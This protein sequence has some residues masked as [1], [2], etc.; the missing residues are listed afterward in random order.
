MYRMNL[1]LLSYSLGLGFTFLRT[2]RFG[3]RFICLGNS[4]KVGFFSL[5]VCSTAVLEYEK[6]VRIVQFPGPFP[7]F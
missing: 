4:P 2:K 3:S 5:G 1:N 6:F 7:R